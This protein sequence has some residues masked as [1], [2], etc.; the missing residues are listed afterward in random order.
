MS[1]GKRGLN[2]P[3]RA[4]KV[5]RK[6]HPGGAQ[7]TRTQTGKSGYDVAGNARCPPHIGPAAGY[8]RFPRP[9]YVLLI[10][11]MEKEYSGDKL[12]S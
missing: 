1:R 12:F 10:R 8:P 6:P 11:K 4:V 3:V 9:Y 7:A 5:Y 2:A